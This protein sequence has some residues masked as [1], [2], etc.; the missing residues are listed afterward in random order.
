M[1]RLSTDNAQEETNNTAVQDEEIVNLQKII[2][3]L[4]AKLADEKK[5]TEDETNNIQIENRD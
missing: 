3:E 4:R 5:T 1:S 2:N